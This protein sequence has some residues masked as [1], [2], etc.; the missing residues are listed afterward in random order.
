MRTIALILILA[1]FVSG[2]SKDKWK[3]SDRM[4]GFY[5]DSVRVYIR[6]DYDEERDEGL[7]DK[8]INEAII[9]YA[10]KRCGNLLYNYMLSISKEGIM[11]KDGEKL[12]SQ[13]LEDNRIVYKSCE[14]DYC[15]A[16]VDFSVKKFRSELKLKK[17]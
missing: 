15:E 2:C 11:N 13:I 3:I 4:E 5:K 17:K 14:D 16:F 7:T 10:K 12:I 6:F 1:F 9:S 8:E